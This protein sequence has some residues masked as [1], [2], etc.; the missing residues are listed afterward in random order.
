[1]RHMQ[2]VAP[3]RCDRNHELF[4]NRVDRNIYDGNLRTP[5]RYSVPVLSTC[6]SMNLDFLAIA[7]KSFQEVPGVRADTSDK[8]ARVNRDFI[9]QNINKT[10]IIGCILMSPSWK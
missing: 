2:Y 8:P 1:M 4:A 3:L 7:R 6:N 9:C 10:G 5:L